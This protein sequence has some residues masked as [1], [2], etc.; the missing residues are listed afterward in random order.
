M[1]L[2]KYGIFYYSGGGIAYVG[3]TCRPSNWNALKQ[4]FNGFGTSASSMG[5]LLAHEIGHNLGM[6][7]DFDTIHGGVDGPCNNQGFMSNPGAPHQWSEC[8]VADF[9]AH[10]ETLASAWCMPGKLTFFTF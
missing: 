4:S 1:Y 9:T 7:H 8:S 3:V 2:N 5:A 10:F 6:S